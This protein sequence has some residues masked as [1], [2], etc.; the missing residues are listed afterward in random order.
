MNHSPN[1]SSPCPR[2]QMIRE[3]GRNRAGGRITYLAK[4]NKTQETVVVKRFLFAQE[5][6]NWSGFKAYEREI[7]VLQGF[8]NP[9]IPR[10]LDSFETKAGF[11]M[12]QEYKNAQSLAIPRTFEP[13]QIKKIAL[14]ILEILIYLQNRLP[15]V[16]HRDIKPENILV[17][18]ELNVYLID[19][20]FA[21]IGNGEAAMSSVAAGTFGFMAPEQIYNRQ[22]SEATDLYGLGATLICLLTGTK[23]TAMDTLINEEGC[24]HFQHLLPKLSLRFVSWLE[25]MVK[26]KAKERFIDAAVALDALHSIDL[27]RTPEVKFSQVMLEFNTT[28]MGEKLTQTIT[29]ENAIPETVLEGNWEVDPHPSDPRFRTKNSHLWISFEPASFQGNQ[30]DCNITVDTNRLMADKTYNRRILLHTNSSPETYVLELNVHTNP[31]PLLKP[32][33]ISLGIVL[34]MSL[35]CTRLWTELASLFVTQIPALGYW[36]GTGFMVGFLGGAVLSAIGVR[37]VQITKIASSLI[38]IMML[39]VIFVAGL[40]GTFLTALVGLAGLITGF[41]TG[42]AI[43][44]HRE[45]GYNPKMAAT[46]PLLMTGLGMSLAMGINFGFLNFWILI[47]AIGTSLSLVGTLFN[48]YWQ[49]QKLLEQYNQSAQKRRLIKP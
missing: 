34:G 13:E 7:Q 40:I 4:D 6:S 47:S 22:L 32:P 2:Y 46:I 49:R 37:G 20:G 14:S 10:Y 17:D 23:S 21:R 3:L 35:I 43:K 12:V 8:D 26:P 45:R 24:I 44:N 11:C 19:F 33:Y 16:I 36:L 5:N 25:K 27:I 9:G 30:V 41:T 29:V 18:E 1:P 28:Q 39:F 48:P 15:A 38:A 31:I 42:A